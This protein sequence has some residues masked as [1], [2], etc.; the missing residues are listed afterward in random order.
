MT[1]QRLLGKVVLITGIAGGMGRETALLFAREGAT[2]IGCDVNEAGC[3]ETEEMV[4]AEGNSIEFTA[5]VDLTSQE[6]VKSWVEGALFR[7]GRLDVLY[8]NASLPK[9]APFEVM[10]QSA[11]QFTMTNELDLVWL[12]CQ[13]AWPYLVASKGNI[14]NIG[15]G[16][17]LLG[18]RTLPQAAHAAAKGAVLALTRQLAAE[19]MSVGVRVNSVSP[20]VMATPPIQRMYDELGANSPVASIVERTITQAPGDPRAVAFA[21]LYLASD[22]AA[23]VT[24]INLVVDGGASAVM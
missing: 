5:P 12:A 11:Y 18:S 7:H 6:Q 17:G 15:S 24:G 16:A 2:V 13:T 9:F 20:G 3:R 4:R 8:N 19:G 1:S 10:S 14:V 22:D 23:W 21:G